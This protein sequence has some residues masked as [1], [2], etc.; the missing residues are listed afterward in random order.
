MPQ[1]PRGDQVDKLL[2]DSCSRDLR[3]E[4][5]AETE[6]L[7]HRFAPAADPESLR[8]AAAVL[9]AYADLF[10]VGR[11]RM[12]LWGAALRLRASHGAGSG[13]WDPP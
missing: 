4:L 10:A 11:S 7:V 8:S 13:T 9:D 3:N 5:E 1:A 6:V 12:K 2:L